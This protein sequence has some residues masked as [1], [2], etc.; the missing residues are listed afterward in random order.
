MILSSSQE[1]K[2]KLSAAGAKFFRPNYGSRGQTLSKEKKSQHHYSTGLGQR[3]RRENFGAKITVP[4]LSK[5]SKSQ[6]YRSDAG[7]KI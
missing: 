2:K 4:P 3:R 6:K 5:K 1:N 7:T